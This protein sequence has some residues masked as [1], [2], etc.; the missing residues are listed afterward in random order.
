MGSVTYGLGADLSLPHYLSVTTGIR[1]LVHKSDHLAEISGNIVRYDALALRPEVLLAWYF[2]C[3]CAVSLE[4]K[5]L[6]HSW[7]KMSA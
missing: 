4:M 1:I 7:E 5:F 2:V 3:A 6:P